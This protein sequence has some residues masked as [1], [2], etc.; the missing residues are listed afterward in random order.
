VATFFVEQ[1]RHNF[2]KASRITEEDDVLIYN[3]RVVFTGRHI[4]DSDSP[5]FDESYIFPCWEEWK[6]EEHDRRKPAIAAI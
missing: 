1:A 3:H 2:H 4:N 5:T 6:K